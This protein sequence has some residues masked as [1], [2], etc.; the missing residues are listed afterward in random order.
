MRH[1]GSEQ[2]ISHMDNRGIAILIIFILIELNK[3]ILFAHRL[4]GNQLKETLN[5]HQS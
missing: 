2:V 1:P 4:Q 5:N 3:K